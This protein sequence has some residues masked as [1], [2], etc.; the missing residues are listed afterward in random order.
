[1]TRVVRGL[2]HPIRIRRGETPPGILGTWD[3]ATGTI[4]LRADL[5]EAS[6]LIILLHEAMH[7][8]ESAMVQNGAI[9]RRVHH[10]FIAC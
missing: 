1:M 10:D 5:D 8:V 4:T 3:E 6:A 2:G 7:V 9:P